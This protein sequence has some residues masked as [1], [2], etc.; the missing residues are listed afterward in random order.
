MPN[1]VNNEVYKR[2]GHAWWDDD[3][4][5]F[6]IIR[7]CV[8][9]VRAGFFLRVLEREREGAGVPRTLLDVGCGG[10]FLSEEFARAG[11]A[12]TGIDPSGPAVEAARRHAEASGLDI[13]YETGSGEALPFSDAAFDVV[14]CCD[15]L[16]HV[17]DQERVVSEIARVLKPGGLFFYDTINRTP[18]SWLAVVKVM[19]DWTWTA[20]AEP[21]TH[22]WSRFIKP[23]ELVVLLDRNGFEN[24]EMRGISPGGNP[25]SLLADFNRRVRGVISFKELG[26]RLRFHESADLGVSY[27]GY[28]VK[29]SR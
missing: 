9:P 2:R 10:G 23:R 11:L 27:M 5:E 26:R 8:N 16:E 1:P 21:E 13:R 4:G 14:A 6:C 12:V 17:D 20:F 24:G 7:F 25:L 28:A 22:V 29:R 3:E 18:M 19:Q 15:V